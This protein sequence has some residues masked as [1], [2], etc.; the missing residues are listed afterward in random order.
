MRLFTVTNLLLL[1]VLFTGTASFAQQ[2]SVTRWNVVVGDSAVRKDSLAFRKD[3]A[4]P[5][6][7]PKKAAILSA[8]LPGAGQVYNGKPGYFW[9]VP[10]IYA[11]FGALTYSTVW[12]NQQYKIYAQAL[13]FRYDDDSTTIDPLPRYSDNDL[14]TLKDYYRRF[15]DLSIIG[16]AALYTLQI[17]DATVDAHLY[18]FDKKMD[19]PLTLNVKPR[20]MYADQRMYPGVCITLGLH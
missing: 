14:V 4:P 17:V 6:H 5:T 19:G 7:S 2:D 20:W 9:K 10:V 11:G 15:R 1:L 16:I 18:Q 12:N 3:K 13:H 8:C